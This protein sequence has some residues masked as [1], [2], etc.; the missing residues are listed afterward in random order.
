MRCTRWPSPRCHSGADPRPK[1]HCCCFHWLAHG[2]GER[3]GGRRRWVQSHDCDG[4]LLAGGA[5]CQAS[6]PLPTLAAI[7]AARIAATATDHDHDGAPWRHWLAAAALDPS[8]GAAWRD[9]CRQLCSC[10]VP[11]YAHA[12]SFWGVGGG[13]LPVPRSACWRSAS[14]YRASLPQL[15]A[16]CHAATWP[17]TNGQRVP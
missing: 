17:A 1:R 12:L 14:G 15:R 10:G 13:P 16:V 3:T 2:A 7:A 11:A 9:G 4:L 6:L 5:H 8:L